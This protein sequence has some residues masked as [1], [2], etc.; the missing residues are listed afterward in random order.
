MGGRRG[1]DIMPGSAAISHTARRPTPAQPTGT[2]TSLC[3]TA[4]LLLRTGTSPRRPR[5]SQ[6]GSAPES[7][8]R[9]SRRWA[10]FAPHPPTT[11]R[12]AAPV[13]L[14]GLSAPASSGSGG[15]SAV[16][17]AGARSSGSS[18]TARSQ[19][20]GNFSTTDF[21]SGF[22]G[23]GGVSAVATAGARSAVAPR[24]PPTPRLR[25]SFRPRTS[26]P[27]PWGA[28]A[29]SRTCRKIRIA[30]DSDNRNSDRTQELLTNLLM[31]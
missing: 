28:P 2:P 21:G 18:G 13:P 10:R 7:T 20:K 29:Y 26:D 23:W 17:T 15:V 4:V 31:V 19:V 24:A 3:A 14:P 6:C 5:L 25:G 8:A 27:P 16:S 12:C 1:Q 11:C 30:P 22:A 9:R